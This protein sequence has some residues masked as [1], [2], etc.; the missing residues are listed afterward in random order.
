MPKLASLTI[1]AASLVLLA[2]C[3]REKDRHLFDGVAFKTK[4]KAVDRKVTLADFYVEVYKAP[5]SMD[6]A[7]QA[8]QFEGISYCIA[9]YGTSQIKWVQDPLDSEV[10]LPLDGDTAVVN[11]R[12]D[13]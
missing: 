7:R 13:P 2:G 10:A 12:C 6:G 9:N 5:L 1:F 8:A 11:G 4:S 3:D